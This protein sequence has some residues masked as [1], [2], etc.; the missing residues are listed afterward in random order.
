MQ[1]R[2]AVTVAGI[3]EE[4]EAR[5]LMHTYG[6]YPIVAERGEGCR[7]WDV[8]GKRYLDFLGGLAVDSLGHAPAVVARALAEQAARLIQTSNLLYTEPQVELAEFL[9]ARSP[10]DKVFFCN[11][12][13]EA[14]EAALKLARKWGKQRRGGAYRTIVAENSFHGRTLATIAATGNAHYRDPFTPLPEGFDFV[15]FNNIDAIADAVSEETVAVLLEPVQAEGGLFPAD[16]QYLADVRQLCD[17][18]NLL[19]ILDEVQ[20][21]VGRCGT[22]WAH[23]QYGIEPDVMTLAKGLASGFPIGAALAK[24]HC[25]VFEPG[26]HASTFGGNP[27]ACAVGLAVQKEIERL[28][29]VE[30]VA[31]VGRYFTERLNDLGAKHPVIREVRGMGLLVGLELNEEIARDVLVSIRERGLIANALN[32]RTMR[33]IPPLIVSQEE[34]DEAVAILDAA[35]SA[36]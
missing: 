11:S 15:P 8:A 33:F 25:D 12:G 4:R 29:L 19:L 31:A 7:L 26:D 5:V 9:V 32:A 22:L 2:G 18:R 20:T 10:F 35:L 21:G 17:E 27:L 1:G 6:R 36:R 16:K 28:N 34:I 30:H 14:N 24:A 23:T 3:W 13:A